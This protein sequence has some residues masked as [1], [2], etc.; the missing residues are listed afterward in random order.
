MISRLLLSTSQNLPCNDLNFASYLFSDLGGTNHLN[1]LSMIQLKSL[2]NKLGDICHN[3]LPHLLPSSLYIFGIVHSLCNSNIQCLSCFLITFFSLISTYL[4]C[5]CLCSTF[6]YIFGTQHTTISA[7]CILPSNAF[8]K[9]WIPN[10][11]KG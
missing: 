7:S 2:Y 8:P 3:P 5:Y 10:A 9:D 11:F 4:Y 6:C 1:P